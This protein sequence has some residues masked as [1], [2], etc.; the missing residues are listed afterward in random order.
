MTKPIPKP[1]KVAAQWSVELVCDCP[2]CEEYVDLLTASDFWDGRRG[3]AVGEHGTP[4]ADNLDV[5]CPECG[6][7]LS[8][9]HI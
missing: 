3:F 1:E 2:K 8:L 7:E 5:C 9:I 4:R 6:H